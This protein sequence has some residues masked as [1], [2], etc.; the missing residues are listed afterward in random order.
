[1][2]NHPHNNRRPQAL[3]RNTR[4][5]C[6]NVPEERSSTTRQRSYSS[7]NQDPTRPNSM[8][9]GRYSFLANRREERKKTIKVDLKKERFPSLVDLKKLKNKKT[10]DNC[11]Q[12]ENNYKEVASYTEEDIQ[13]LQKKKEQQKN[14]RNLKGWVHIC[15]N[16]GQTIMSNMDKDGKK[17]VIN[18]SFQ[19]EE[20][21]KKED[22]DH[23]T[24][25]L[26]CAKVMYN[27]LSIIQSARD[28]ENEILGLHSRY[29]DKGSL[30]D[31]SYLSDSDIESSDDE[32]ENKSD[33]EYYSDGD[34]Y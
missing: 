20:N 25:Q 9:S 24:F 30:I 1:M 14:K 28:E 32:D 29:Y 23:N 31:L 7:N 33:Q 12:L 27:N 11:E 2:F 26:L 13:K 4:F 10:E 3:T 15:N 5:E 17:S 19:E 18:T 34:T 8:L 21:E 16:N 22:V 6:L